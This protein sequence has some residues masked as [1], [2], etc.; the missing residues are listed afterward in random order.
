MD[1]ETVNFLV[2]VVKLSKLQKL[3]LLELFES[4]EKG[5]EYSCISD[6][7]AKLTNNIISKKTV[8]ERK[9]ELFNDLKQ[10]LKNAPENET[11]L[12]ELFKIALNILQSNMDN[13]KW[14][15]RKYKL[16]PSFKAS[17]SRVIKRL[18]NRNL[19]KS[20]N[21]YIP[22][23]YLDEKNHALKENYNSKDYEK[24]Y[25]KYIELTELGTNV[26]KFLFTNSI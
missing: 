9:Q 24:L 17:F 26:C 18:E 2:S 22:Y 10:G 7:I 11:L 14:K 13:N 16:N 6:I 4:K 25:R 15:F 3:I 1:N 12:L 21:F 5:Y 23:Y 19:I 8:N 20:Y